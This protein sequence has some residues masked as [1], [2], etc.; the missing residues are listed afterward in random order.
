MVLKSTYATMNELVYTTGERQIVRTPDI[1]ARSTKARHTC[2]GHQGGRGGNHVV[3]KDYRL[4]RRTV[5]SSVLCGLLRRVTHQ[6]EA[7][8]VENAGESE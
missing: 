2:L 8:G 5:R 4:T 3:G 7:D 1:V 6:H